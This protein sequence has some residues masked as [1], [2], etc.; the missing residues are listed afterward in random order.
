[1]SKGI[2]FAGIDE[3]IELIVCKDRVFSPLPDKMCWRK[4]YTYQVWFE[5]MLLDSSPDF[6]KYKEF[7]YLIK[8]LYMN[9]NYSVFNREGKE[10]SKG[11][12][13]LIRNLVEGT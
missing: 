7:Y 8:D 9:T 5:D 12:F 11:E 1:M 6:Q 4:N 3:D 2:I 10:L 13:K